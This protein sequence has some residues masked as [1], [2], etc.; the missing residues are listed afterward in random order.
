MINDKQLTSICPAIK[1]TLAVLISEKLS[2][3]CP[4]Y[5]ISTPDIFHEFIAN[6]LEECGEF[7]TFTE[8]LNYSAEALISK[9]GRHRISVADA[10]KYGRIDGKQKADQKAIANILYGGKWGRIN[11]GNTEPNDGWNFRGS[12]AIQNTGRANISK[13]A[14]YYNNRFK[15]NYSV[16]EVAEL[17]RIDL[18]I[19]IHSACW[20][21]AIAKDLI[22]EAIDD[23]MLDIV[24]KINGGTNGL[25]KRLIYLERAKKYIV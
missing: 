9:F 25:S 1:G 23:K 6:V 22:Q 14:K 8:N 4:Q 20:F 18:D 12:G 13:F 5:G 24:K 17:L 2:K 21:F 16:E 7:T 15:T 10:K 19:S 3:I 11:L